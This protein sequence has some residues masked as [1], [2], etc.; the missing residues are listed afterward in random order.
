M[1]A[2][3]LGDPVAR[4]KRPNPDRDKIELRAD[5]AWIGRVTD[6][7]ESLGVSLSAFVRLAINERLQRMES[8]FP[9]RKRKK[10]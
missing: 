5:P 4:P 9:T 8:E 3:L 1:R 6:A 10:T 7:A 2:I